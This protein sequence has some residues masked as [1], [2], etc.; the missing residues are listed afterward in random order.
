MVER[1]QNLLRP[2]THV[3]GHSRQAQRVYEAR[4]D[5]DDADRYGAVTQEYIA[6]LAGLRP[7]S[8]HG[9]RRSLR[10]LSEQEPAD[11]PKQRSCQEDRHENQQLRCEAGPSIPRVAAPDTLNRSD[12]P[13]LHLNPPRVDENS[14]PRAE[15]GRARRRF[16]WQSRCMPAP[17]PTAL[18]NTP[19]PPLRFPNLFPV[20]G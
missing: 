1:V 8:A 10:V 15:G 9:V 13:F 11:K 16:L 7:L 14:D 19:F 17:M 12:S 3:G 20:S 18:A 6:F 2:A 5:A 4:Q